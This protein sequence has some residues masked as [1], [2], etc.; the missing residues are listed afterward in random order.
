[1]CALK[2]MVYCL[3]VIGLLGFA[4]NHEIKPVSNLQMDIDPEPLKS[5]N[6]NAE[7]IYTGGNLRFGLRMVLTNQTS[8]SL[9]LLMPMAESISPMK[10]PGI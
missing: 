5:S 7:C 9:W 8:I 2:K 4:T 3:S 6:I 10:L 1:M